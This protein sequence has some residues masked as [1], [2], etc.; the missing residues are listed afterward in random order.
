MSGT[1]VGSTLNEITLE[2]HSSNGGVALKKVGLYGWDSVALAW[3]RLLVDASGNLQAETS[4][5][6][7]IA[8]GRKTVTTAGT[9][10]V[11][12][13]STSCKRV[14]VQALSDN[15]DLVYVGGS[16]VV[17]ADNTENGFGLYATNSAE[18]EVNNLNLIY[19]DSRVSGEGVSFV[20]VV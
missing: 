15:T 18:F 9:R 13:A 2:E 3:V 17:A 1:N 19:I 5:Y 12:A 16:D 20:Y 6:G 4:S 14:K 8:G 7:T 10:V 11:L